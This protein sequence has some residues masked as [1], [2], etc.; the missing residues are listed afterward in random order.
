[1]RGL[2]HSERERR[3]AAAARTFTFC[4]VRP[5]LASK[6]CSFLTFTP[7]CMDMDCSTTAHRNLN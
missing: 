2:L 3:P 5:I 7:P 6:R 4:E 1:M